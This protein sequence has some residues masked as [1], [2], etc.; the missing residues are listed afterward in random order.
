MNRPTILV[1]GAI[2]KTGGAV[3][4]QLREQGW[5][6]RAVVRARDARSA[7]LD[8]LGAETVVADLHDPDQMRNAMQGT[9]RAYYCPPFDPY[10]IESASVFAVA[11]RA[12]KLETIVMLSQWLASPAHPA[13][14]TR[15]HRLVDR[16]FA[17][18]PGMALTVVNPGFF[19]DDYPTVFGMAAQLGTFPSPYGDSRNAPPSNEDIA[20]VAVAALTDPGKHAGKRYR[21]TGPTLLSA[22]DMAGILGRV[23]R[24]K[25]RK[26][27]MPLWLFLKAARLQGRGAFEMSSFRHY[28]LDHQQGAFAVGAPTAKAPC[29]W[30]RM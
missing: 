18:I 24:R 29:W 2:G 15:Q 13:L 30:S 9:T 22:D 10:M 12:A 16:L 21:P 7:R 26:M 3:V 14:L 25:V 17:T 1:T 8:R 23:L 5:P 19:A 27:E 28:I 11:A 6:V 4:S 20:R